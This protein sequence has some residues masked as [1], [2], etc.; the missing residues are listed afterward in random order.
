MMF[1]VAVMKDEISFTEI[2]LA[3]VKI[4]STKESFFFHGIIFSLS[5]GNQSRWWRLARIV[6]FVTPYLWFSSRAQIIC[7][8]ICPYNLWVERK[9]LLVIIIPT[10]KTN[11]G[12][13]NQYILSDA[14]YASLQIVTSSQNAYPHIQ[15]AQKFRT[16]LLTVL[17]IFIILVFVTI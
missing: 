1:H 2:N 13:K 14:I 10:D 9:F 17:F 12:F 16:I 11:T 5:W 7:S 8:L 15:V 3:T 4:A 6:Q